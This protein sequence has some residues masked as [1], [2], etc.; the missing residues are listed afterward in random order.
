MKK[1]TNTE[2][3]IFQTISARVNHTLDS[4][5]IRAFADKTFKPKLQNKTF[6]KITFLKD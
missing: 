4:R 5:P 1:K 6:W 3:H 2:T